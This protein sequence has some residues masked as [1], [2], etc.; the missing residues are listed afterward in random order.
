MT[1]PRKGCLWLVPA[2]LEQVA[3][4]R[5]WLLES[6]RQT[7]ARLTR[8]YVETPKTARAWLGALPMTQP[9]QAID[10]I[11]LPDPRQT[12]DWPALLR[13]LLAGEDAGLMSDAGCPG[14]ADPGAALVAQAHQA[15]IEVRPLIGPSSLLLALMASG[16]EGQRFAFHGYLPVGREA[17]EAQL[18]SLARRST[19]HDETQILIETPY[20]N[21]AMTESLLRALPGA[22][23]LCLACDLTGTEERVV[24]RTVEQWRRIPVSPAPRRP[25]VFLFHHRAVR[26]LRAP[27]PARGRPGPGPGPG[28]GPAS[29]K[30][31]R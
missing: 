20:R 1:A 4:P 27:A 10:L 16:L 7:V 15:G 5:P 23:R 6:D 13:P 26:E 31:R 18:A 11:T 12:I 25:M 9:L 8:F 29:A 17:R 19:E 2:P 30:R 21:D 28:S 22:A 3:L 24:T 14:V